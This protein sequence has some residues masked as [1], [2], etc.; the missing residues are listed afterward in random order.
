MEL[1][2]TYLPVCKVG[3]P[4]GYGDVE[5][6]GKP[7][8]AMVRFGDEVIDGEVLYVCQEHLEQIEDESEDK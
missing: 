8:V 2:V 5:N 7:A 3:V 4:D 1:R 6:C